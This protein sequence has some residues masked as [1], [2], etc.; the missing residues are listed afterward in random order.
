MPNTYLLCGPTRF[1]TE[2]IVEVIGL[3]KELPSCNVSRHP[4]IRCSQLH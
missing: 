3:W 1:T 4:I 2:N